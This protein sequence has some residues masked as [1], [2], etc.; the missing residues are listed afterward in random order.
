VRSIRILKSQ[1]PSRPTFLVLRQLICQFDPPELATGACVVPRRQHV[2]IIKATRRDID[3]VW[4]VCVLESQLCPALWTETP[5]GLRSRPKPGRLT[6]HEAELGPRHAEPCDE[7]SAGGSTADRAM[8][9]CFIKG[10]AL[11]LI[12]NLS[13]KASA[14]QHSITCRCALSMTG[15]PLSPRALPITQ[16]H[17]SS[18]IKAS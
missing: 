2:W 1:L 3:F 14:V 15:F 8:A 4:E 13:T 11:C 6:A 7:R 16:L 12:T 9:V 17:F 5:R 10:H 18:C